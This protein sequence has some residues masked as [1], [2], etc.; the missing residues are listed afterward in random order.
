MWLQSAK[1]SVVLL[2]ILLLLLKN[3]VS[4]AFLCENHYFCIV[5]V[6][7]WVRGGAVA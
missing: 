3:F 2:E 6:T 1:I 7:C 5:T 4:T